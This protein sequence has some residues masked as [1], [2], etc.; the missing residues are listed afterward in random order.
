M[1]IHK[2]KWLSFRYPK[3]ELKEQFLLCVYNVTSADLSLAT[4][5]GWP[6]FCNVI[7]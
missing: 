5:L 3:H 2:F 1:A 4:A 7:G 6:R